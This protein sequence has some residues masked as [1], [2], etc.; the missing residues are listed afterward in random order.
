MLGHEIVDHVESDQGS[1]IGLR[2]LP[3]DT[4]FL[5][6]KV[7]RQR[8]GT[9]WGQPVSGYEIHHGRVT[10]RAGARTWFNLEEGGEGVMSDDG[11]VLGT[12]LHGLLEEDGFRSAFLTYVAKRRGKSYSPSGLR[13]RAAREDQFDRLAD[14]LEA[15]LDLPALDCILADGALPS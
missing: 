11:A 2:S 1:V 14:L 4:V 3:V 10:A 5:A 12:N 9:A 7:T 13:F 15:H 6:E 8:H